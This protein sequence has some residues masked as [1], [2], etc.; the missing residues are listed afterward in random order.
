[1]VRHFLEHRRL[2]LVHARA[3]REA[4]AGGV[5]ARFDG[6]A[7]EALALGLEYAEAALV[8]FPVAVSD[9]MLFV[10][11]APPRYRVLVRRRRDKERQ[12]SGGFAV[13]SQHRSPI[14]PHAVPTRLSLLCAAPDNCS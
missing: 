2:L 12:K 11:C 3:A 7:L 6:A 1:M 4:H 10:L 9:L 8:A 13:G 5:G 14:E